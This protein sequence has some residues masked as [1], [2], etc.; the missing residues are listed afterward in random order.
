MPRASAA[1]SL[2]SQE[3]VRKKGCELSVCSK[4]WPLALPDERG[5]APFASLTVNLNGA[6]SAPRTA[7]GVLAAGYQKESGRNW[8]PVA[9]IAARPEFAA[10]GK[11]YSSATWTVASGATADG[12]LI[13]TR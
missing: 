3:P 2:T 7:N 1:P 8:L 10:T 12:R 6:V 11:R 9:E 4:V 13:V 5:V